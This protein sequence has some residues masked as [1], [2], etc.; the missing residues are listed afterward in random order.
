[1]AHLPITHY[2]LFNDPFDRFFGNQL[3]FFDPWRDFDTFPRRSLTFQNP[4]RWINEPHRTTHRWTSSFRSSS[5]SFGSGNNVHIPVTN[6][7]LPVHSEKFRVQLDVAGFNPETIQ[8]RVEDGK[9]IVE[10]KQEDRQFN[11]DFSLREI[12]KTYDL[13]M[14]AG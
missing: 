2:R 14:H 12:R 6:T 5:S 10:G 3:D 4:F 9:V 13:P 8:T 11:G 1:M 7:F